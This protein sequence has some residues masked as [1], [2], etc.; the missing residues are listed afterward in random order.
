MRPRRPLPRTRTPRAP[1]PRDARARKRRLGIT[2]VIIIII[3][4]IVIMYHVLLCIMCYVWLWLCSLSLLLS[5][6]S[7]VVVVVVVV[8]GGQLP[9]R[10]LR[11]ISVLRFW[12]QRVWLKQHLNRKGWILMSKGEGRAAPNCRQLPRIVGN[13]CRANLERAPG[14]RAGIPLASVVTTAAGGLCFSIVT[15]CYRMT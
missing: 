4:I 3:N 11:P 13:S 5:L 2:T 10:L 12:I 6:S 14:R 7:L 1:P 8:R 9:S 15:V